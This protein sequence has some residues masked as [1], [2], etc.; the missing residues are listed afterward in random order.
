MSNI[1][2]ELVCFFYKYLFTLGGIFTILNFDNMA[3]AILRCVV[4]FL[5]VGWVPPFYPGALPAERDVRRRFNLTDPVSK[6]RCVVYDERGTVFGED[7]FKEPVEK[8]ISVR[9]L[10]RFAVIPGCGTNKTV[11][12]T[13]VSSIEEGAAVPVF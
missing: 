1:L 7:I 13:F 9:F 5:S 8:Y 4:P 10:H 3:G 2:Y 11:I 6:V 12:C